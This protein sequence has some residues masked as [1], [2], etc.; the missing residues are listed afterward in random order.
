MW[1]VTGNAN[2]CL[3]NWQHY[4][5]GKNPKP[6]V[7]SG[8]SWGFAII[9]RDMFKCMRISRGHSTRCYRWASSMVAREARRIGMDNRSR[10]RVG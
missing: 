1:L 3:G 5:T 8:P 9:I 7:N 10:R 2:P 4:A 6:S